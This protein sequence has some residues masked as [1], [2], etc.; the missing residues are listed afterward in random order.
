MLLREWRWLEGIEQNDLAV[1]L[2]FSQSLIS[3]VERTGSASEVFKSAFK[4][5]FGIKTYKKIN[6][7]KANK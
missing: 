6:E 1:K 5:A 7:F 4:S 3:K 2:G